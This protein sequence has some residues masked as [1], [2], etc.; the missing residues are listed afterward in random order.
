M[1]K[2]IITNSPRET[3]LLGENFSRLLK[4]K[5]VVA[6][7]GDLAAGKTTLIKGICRGKEIETRVDSPT[8]TLINEYQGEIPIYHI[9]CYR[10]E[11]TKG[12]VEIGIEEYFY[13]DGITLVEWAEKIQDLL[14][15]EYIQVSIEQDFSKDTWRKFKFNFPNSDKR[16]Y[17]LLNI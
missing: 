13:G 2:E 15:S 5:D 16:R 7:F 12:W 17:H 1:N 6:F 11:N 3:I 9:D 8:Y 10:E 4:K 14:P